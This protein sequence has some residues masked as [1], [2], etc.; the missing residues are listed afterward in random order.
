MI[1]LQQLTQVSVM[2]HGPLISQL[3]SSLTE[4]LVVVKV[5]VD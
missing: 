5:E 1:N 2:A 4:C 3:R